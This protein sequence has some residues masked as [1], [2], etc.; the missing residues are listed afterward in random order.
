MT[1]TDGEW[2]YA[3]STRVLMFQNW[4]VYNMEGSRRLLT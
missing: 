3:T 4:F 1:W 2:I